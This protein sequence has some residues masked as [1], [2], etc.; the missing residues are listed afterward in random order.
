MSKEGV[1]AAQEALQGDEEEE[2][3]EEQDGGTAKATKK[4]DVE[5]RE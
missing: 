3:D 5:E 4:K 2:G 1:E